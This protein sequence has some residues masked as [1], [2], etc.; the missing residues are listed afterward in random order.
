M[1]PEFAQALLLAA[2]A[3][4]D[5][6]TTNFL[7]PNGTFFAELLIFLVVFGV[8]YKFAWPF[9]KKVMTERQDMIRRQI[10]ES[11]KTNEKL[12]AAEQKYNEALDEAR[13][14]AAKIRDEARADAGRIKEELRVQAEAEVARIR[15]RGEEQLTAQREQA[16]RELR[17]QIGDLSVTL[18]GRIV[19]D[20]L[21][22]EQARSATVDRFIDELDGMSATDKSAGR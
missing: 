13:T 5:E 4:E 3:E 1:S 15:Q 7:I 12:A 19:G 11:E 14:E 18:A 17:A 20:S 8:I 9:I 6:E 22:N 21:A 16:V 2:E 10:E